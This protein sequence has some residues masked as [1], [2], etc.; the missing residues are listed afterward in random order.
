MS[1]FRLLPGVLILLVGLA[2]VVSAQ[3]T[4]KHKFVEG[5]EFKTQTVQK[6]E[7]TLKLAGTDIP[8]K[9]DLNLVS[10]TTYGQRDADKNVPVQSKI[11][12]VVASLSVQGMTVTFDSARPDEKASNPVLQAALDQ[13]RKL[14]GMVINHTVNPE[15]NKIVSV[16]RPKGETLVDPDDLK[17]EYQQ[18]LEMFPDKPLKPGDKWERTVRQDLGQGQVFTFKRNY[19]FVGEVP[20]FATV[21][22][23][24]KLEKITAT[25]AS[26][27]YSIKAGGGMGLTVKSSELKVESSKHTYLFDRQAGRTVDNDSEVRV[28]GKLVLSVN[29]MDLDAVF[30]LTMATRKQEVKSL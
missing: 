17:D 27:E 28:S 6:V 25:D 21:P 12:S 2:P 22:G 10:R 15:S 3:T 19:E 5:T 9:V 24:R 26:V 11:E 8:T 18:E 4:L 30:D 29:N 20:E 16:E 14:N 13:F 1:R 23:S 7:Q